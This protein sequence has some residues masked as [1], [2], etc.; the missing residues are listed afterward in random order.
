MK[1]SQRESSKEVSKDRALF[2][3]ISLSNL[4]KMVVL[5]K[6]QAIEAIKQ[7]ARRK[8]LLSICAL[9]ESINAKPWHLNR[10]YQSK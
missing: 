6:N 5:T 8:T 3:I 10:R 7:E 4:N 1:I 9:T 2:L